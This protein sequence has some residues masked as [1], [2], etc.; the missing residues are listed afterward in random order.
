MAD[1]YAIGLRLLLVEELAH[2][3]S[4]SI[5]TA[6]LPDV[7][8]AEELALYDVNRGLIVAVG[9]LEDA[10][11]QDVELVAGRSG[12]F[13]RQLYEWQITGVRRL[14]APVPA[15]DVPDARDPRRGMWAVPSHVTDEVRR[16]LVEVGQ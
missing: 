15:R 2:A 14:A 7:D 13:G 8:E 1:M 3:G 10:V 6:L 16:Q 9:T 11:E 5:T 4:G 12:A